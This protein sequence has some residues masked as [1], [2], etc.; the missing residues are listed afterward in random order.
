[1][2]YNVAMKKCFRCKLTKPLTDFYKH[3]QMKDGHLNKC[4]ECSRKDV[5]RRY[6]DPESNLKIRE[7][8]KKRFQDPE[9]KARVT[10]YFRKMRQNNPD[11]FKARTK[12][13]NAVRDGVIAREPCEVCGHHK[14]EAHHPDYNEPL[15]VKWLCRRHHLEEHDRQSWI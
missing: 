13:N 5:R 10:E 7:Y 14:V 8:E 11:K 1:M 4:K 9:R 15:N 2:V 6:Y 3:K 12:L